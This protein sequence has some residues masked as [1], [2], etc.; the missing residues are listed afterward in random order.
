MAFVDTGTSFDDVKE[1]ESLPAGKYK[2]T[3]EGAE[4]V[5]DAGKKP[6]VSVR[7][8][9]EGHPEAKAIFHNMYLPTAEDPTEKRANKLLFIKRFLEKFKI[10]FAGAKFDTDTFQG[11][12]AE[13]TLTQEEYPEGSRV[14]NNKI[15]L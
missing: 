11:R 9:A 2:L 1:K 5:N 8:S 6:N 10:P 12:S 15:K 7:L 14:F 3:I 4:V 13:C